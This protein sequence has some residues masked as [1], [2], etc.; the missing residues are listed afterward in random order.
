[1]KKTARNAVARDLAS[2]KYAVRIVACAK[3]K[4]AYRRRKK[5]RLCDH[6]GASFVSR[7][8]GASFPKCGDIWAFFLWSRLPY[9]L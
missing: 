4:G 9:V 2:R 1:M 7:G 6:G 5:H 3:G 8:S